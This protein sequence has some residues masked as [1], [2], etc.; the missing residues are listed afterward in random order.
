MLTAPASNSTAARNTRLPEQWN[1]F[2]AR[3]FARYRDAWRELNERSFRSPVLDP[4]FIEP[5][6]QTFGNGNERLAVWGHP[7]QPQAMT[8]IGR[9]RSGV[10][11]TFQPNVAPLGPWVAQNPLSLEPL[12]SGLLRAVP[13]VGLLVGLTQQDPTLTPR[14]DNTARLRTLD[15]IQTVRVPVTGGFE[16]YWAQRGKNLRHNLRRQHNRLTKEGVPAQF[17]VLQSP[18]DM[19]GAVTDYGRIESAGWKSQA[20]TA[21]NSDNAQGR[22]YIDMLSRFAK[23]GQAFVFRYLLSGR[24]AAMDLCI[25]HNGVLIILKTAYDE[26]HAPYSP[27]S[28]MREEAFR[29]IFQRNDI[30]VIEFYG[31]LMEWHTKWADDVRTLYHINVYRWP[32]LPSLL[33]L[34]PNDVSTAFA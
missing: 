7:Q 11:E 16:A 28:L 34:M 23:R 24:V 29:W 21:V 26:T 32:F 27:A 15:Y 5:L 20:G 33:H 17:D 9:R 30:R 8:L 22:F 13:G 1:L 25:V 10:W 31:R 2:D 12:L 14:P 4:D 6:L 18:Q 19:H 3:E